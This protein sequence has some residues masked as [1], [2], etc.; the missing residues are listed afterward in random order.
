MTYFFHALLIIIL[1]VIIFSKENLK[2]V[3]YSSV[4]SLICAIL[5]FLYNAPDVALAEAVIGSAIVPLIYIISISKH[6]K[7][8][9]HIDENESSKKNYTS[10]KEVEYD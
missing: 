2:I 3:I 9:S 10:L 8:A 5:Y 4:F 6:S 7:S 1:I